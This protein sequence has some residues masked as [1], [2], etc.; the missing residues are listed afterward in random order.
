L[1]RLWVLLY[2]QVSVFDVPLLHL[3]PQVCPSLL[4]YTSAVLQLW[5]GLACRA[6]AGVWDRGRQLGTDSHAAPP[7]R[8]LPQ[9][10]CLP[11]DPPTWLGQTR[12]DVAV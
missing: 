10:P 6:G 3:L 7:N 8:V 2:A 11:A 12:K 4:K 1:L 9:L 5:R